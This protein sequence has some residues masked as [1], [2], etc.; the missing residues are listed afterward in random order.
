TE[1]LQFTLGENTELFG[2][3]Q[4]ITEV[5]VKNG[6]SPVYRQNMAEAACLHSQARK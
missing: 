3:L 6:I 1:N 2:R 5:S 4:R